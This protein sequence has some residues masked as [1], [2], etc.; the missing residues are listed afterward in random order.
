[1]VGLTLALDLARRGVQCV[2]LDDNDTVSAGSRSTA[3]AR[4]TM[5]IWSR[6]GCAAPMEQK[7][8]PWSVGHIHYKTNKVQSFEVFP[9]GG[10]R[11]PSFI[12]LAQFYVEY[13]LVEAARQI[14]NLDIRWLNR[15][16]AVKADKDA[17]ELLIETPDGTYRISADWVVAADGA[18]STVRGS[19]GLPFPGDRLL[20][21]F[22]IA[23]I[24]C[25]ADF[26]FE[27][28]FWFDPPFCEGNTVLRVPQS[29]SI[30]RFDWQIDPHGDSTHELSPEVINARLRRILG[31]K[32]DFSVEWISTYTSE[33]RLMDSFRHGR[34]FFAGDA[35]HQFSPFGGGRGGNSGVQ[36][37]DN[38]GWKLAAVVQGKAG[39]QLLDSYS[40]ERRPIAKNN[41]RDSS[42]STAFITPKNDHA[43]VLHEAVLSLAAV[44]PFAKKFVNTG[45]FSVWPVLD[46]SPLSVP[47]A[48]AF[49]RSARPGS[50]V[51]DCALA[52][53]AGQRVWLTNHVGDD[54][55]LVVYGGDV[56]E[57]AS[58]VRRLSDIFP[59]RLVHI[60]PQQETVTDAAFG[61]VDGA[62]ARQYDAR[63][64]TVYLFRPDQ[65]VLGRW[66][67]LD[68]PATERAVR[69]CLARN[70]G[71]AG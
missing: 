13:Y 70:E 64:G 26:P 62:F 21:K 68:A 11:F 1:M 37:A 19:L 16:V 41:I 18:K 71:E 33:H 39:Q 53:S 4:R 55:T 35:A 3:Q 15:V 43:K 66:R 60:L 57:A 32:V 23:D 48:D 58:V 14:P 22:V 49:D 38:L 44:A 63:P 12:S 56:A 2:L 31:S 42:K 45:R 8:I 51:F 59:S 6:L 5:E 28:N 47:D 46:A 25:N 65:H 20:D 27:R 30:W 29:D 54:F 40:A 10:S 69:A 52:D 67:T 61:D 36:D 34:V 7:G 50:P 17:V 24:R 9:E